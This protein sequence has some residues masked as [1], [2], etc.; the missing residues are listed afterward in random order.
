MAFE[1]Y[2]A[3]SRSSLTF[4]TEEEALA[5]ARRRFDQDQVAF[6]DLGYDDGEEYHIVASGQELVR[7]TWP[8]AGQF[9]IIRGHTTGGASEAVVGRA[10]TLGLKAAAIIFA[11]LGLVGGSDRV[12]A[13]SQRDLTVANSDAPLVVDLER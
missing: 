6:L 10:P 11:T 2:D 7:R 12:R 9:I 3:A 13:Q 5:F 1:L 8:A 4:S